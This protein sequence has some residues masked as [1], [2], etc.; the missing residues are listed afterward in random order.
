MLWYH[1]YP[2]LLVQETREDEEH[3]VDCVA[4]SAS[5]WQTKII[6]TV[7]GS[8]PNNVLHQYATVDGA[9]CLARFERIYSFC[10]CPYLLGNEMPYADLYVFH[11]INGDGITKEKLRDYPNLT[12]LHG[13]VEECPNV[14]SYLASLENTN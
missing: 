2:P 14:K 5:D 7:L 11:C 4:D 10:E 8:K 6:P 12:K 3:L 9:E 1:A 13:A